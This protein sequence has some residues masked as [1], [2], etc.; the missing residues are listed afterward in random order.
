MNTEQFL[1]ERKVEDVF[2]A[3]EPYT[4]KEFWSKTFD[5]KVHKVRTTTWHEIVIEI[6]LKE[7]TPENRLQ[8]YKIQE[9]NFLNLTAEGFEVY[10]FDHKGKSPYNR[11]YG[12]EQL[13]GKN[14]KQAFEQF[15]E[16]Y[17]EKLPEGFTYD[18]SFCGE[19]HF[20]PIEFGTHYKYGTIHNLVNESK[21]VNKIDFKVSEAS[22]IT[23]RKVDLDYW[24]ILKK[25]NPNEQER[26]SCIMQI[27][28]A[29]ETMN[30]K[31]MLDYICKHNRWENFNPQITKEKID[32]V[33]KYTAKVNP[34][35][36]TQTED[37]PTLQLI[38]FSDYYKIFEDTH[39]H[40]D[41]Y[42]MISENVGLIGE[43]YY[44]LKKCLTYQVESMRQPTLPFYVG[45]EFFDNRIHILLQG[46]AGTGKTKCKNIIQARGEEVIECSGQRTNIE[47]LIGKKMKVKGGSIEN[48]GYFGYKGLVLD[49]AQMLL[50][51]EDKTLAAIM[52]EI[53]LAMDI[54]G[55]NKV[56]KK[57]V[58]NELPLSYCPETRFLLM[59]H[60]TMYPPVFFDTGTFRR[61]FA[62]V[63]KQTK[64][65]QY[66]TV[67]N[68]YRTTTDRQMK[69]YISNDSSS[70][71][72]NLTFPKETIDEIVDWFLMWNRFSFLNPNRRIRGVCKGLIFSGK[73][74]FFKMAAVLALSKNESRVS[75]ETARLACRDTIHFLL[76]TVE[77]YGNRSM[78][79][80]SRDVWKTSNQQECMLFEWLQ[81]NR[82]TSREDSHLMIRDV[83]MQIQDIFG[84]MEKQARRVYIDLKKKG[85]I[86][87]W[88]QGTDTKCWLAFQPNLDCPIDFEVDTFPD[89]KEWITKK[90]DSSS[91]TKDL[92]QQPN[93]CM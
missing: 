4:K 34:I 21:G 26:V 31:D 92:N 88:R 8:A 68:L 59:I 87:D 60:E 18:F 14:K 56:E 13:K 5:P 28:N 64:V 53:R 36:E 11:L 86:D 66:D 81:Y 39:S 74:Y 42:Q 84:L 22:A 45:S 10:A 91:P 72:V 77:V 47:Q 41:A 24:L 17:C 49:E 20:C 38:D 58:D 55:K 48:K 65:K 33:W 2:F 44:A 63:L 79:T 69:E 6:D 3:S 1:K 82:A 46:S 43:E 78:S 50:C 73:V 23:E 83:Q 75:V 30:K 12:F 80:L 15:V 51:E 93:S 37:V 90:F 16:T 70:G 7:N 27:Y 25:T 61:M 52:R 32:Y 54:Y 57:L 67:A 35:S 19:N 40:L 85:F 29:H 71:I 76:K 62:F 89:L 9:K